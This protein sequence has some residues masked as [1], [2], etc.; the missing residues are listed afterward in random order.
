MYIASV[1]TVTFRQLQ[2]TSFLVL[3]LTI[4]LL[5]TTAIFQ[6]ISFKILLK[7][8]KATDKYRL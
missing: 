1:A 8:E 3:H 6:Y 4:P 5:F 2:F 7:L